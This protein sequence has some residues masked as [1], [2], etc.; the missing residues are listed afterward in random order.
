M[1]DTC[2]YGVMTFD[3]SRPGLVKMCVSVLTD[4]AYVASPLH[5]WCTNG[6]RQ[7]QADE[8]RAGHTKDSSILM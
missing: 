3:E 1:V 7:A 2:A 5:Q 8:W 4:S 6:H